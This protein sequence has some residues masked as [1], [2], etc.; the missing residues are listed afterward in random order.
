MGRKERGR[1][2]HEKILGK[3]WEE[4]TFHRYEANMPRMMISCTQSVND[5]I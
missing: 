4:S 3:G 2:I 5:V 1:G